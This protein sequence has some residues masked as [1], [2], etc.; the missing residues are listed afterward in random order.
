MTLGEE[1]PRDE[2]RNSRYL[3][4]A[5]HADD[6]D[7]WRAM[8]DAYCG[9]YEATIGAGV[10]ECTWSR[11]LAPESPVNCVIAVDRSSGLSVGFANYV[12]HP[13]TWSDRPACYLEDLF[14]Q[15]SA[16]GTGA[17]GALLRYFIA[18]IREQQ[19][20]R[21]YWMTQRNNHVAR[22]LYER[23]AAHDDFIRYV[24]T[25]DRTPAG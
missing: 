21:L 10:T 14:V 18:Q 12:I 24:V 20:G 25:S 2:P 23:F 17:G 15:P 19:W 7:A 11:I 4:R 22:R 6:R 9:F 5:A 13:F 3:V 8:W 1:T 16:R